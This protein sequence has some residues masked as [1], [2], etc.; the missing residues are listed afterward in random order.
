MNSVIPD[1][2]LSGEPADAR[3]ER[4]FSLR[5]ARRHAARPRAL[6][7]AGHRRHAALAWL[8]SRARRL[9][10]RPRRGIARKTRW[11]PRRSGAH[12]KNSVA[13]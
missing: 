7:G 13:A 8:S 3:A 10:W 5:H 2:Q 6:A 9:C 12:W 11:T 1:Q 4:C